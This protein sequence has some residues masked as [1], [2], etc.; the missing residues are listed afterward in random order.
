M[1]NSILIQDN[2]VRKSIKDIEDKINR[3]E[4]IQQLQK[5]QGSSV[6]VDDFNRLIDT[7][8]KITNSMKRRG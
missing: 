1:N 5:I 2:I 6:G 3:I 4:D 8:N 7:I